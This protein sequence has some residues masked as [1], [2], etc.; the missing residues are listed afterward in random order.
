M[1]KKANYL[2]SF[3]SAKEDLLL[4]LRA[5]LFFF[6]PMDFNTYSITGMVF[7]KSKKFIC[8]LLEKFTTLRSLLS[9]KLCFIAKM[10]IHSENLAAGISIAV[11]NALKVNYYSN[12]TNNEQRTF[13]F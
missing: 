10:T 9:P 1:N 6:F 5:I 3:S 7:F 12:P 4:G 2:W 13:S 11:K 8:F